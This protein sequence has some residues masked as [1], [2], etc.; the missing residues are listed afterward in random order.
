MDYMTKIKELHTEL[1]KIPINKRYK[2]G[3]KGVD[4]INQIGRLECEL[5]RK[6]KEFMKEAE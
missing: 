4:L 3:G 5:D 1:D 6:V 2:L